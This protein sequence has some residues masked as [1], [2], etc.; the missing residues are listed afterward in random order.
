MSGPSDHVDTK[1]LTSFHLELN[2][3]ILL[4]DI[5]AVH[6]ESLLVFEF[7]LFSH[8]RQIP[9]KSQRSGLVCGSRGHRQL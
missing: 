1:Y 4:S 6:V 2:K 5:V 3:P 9:G 7:S 8:V